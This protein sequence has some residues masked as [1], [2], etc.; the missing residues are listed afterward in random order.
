VIGAFEGQDAGLS[1]G[2]QRRLDRRFDRVGARGRE[3]G[4]HGHRRESGRIR[5][6]SLGAR[7]GGLSGA[8]WV[9]CEQLL[10]QLDLHAR[11]VDVSHSVHQRLGLGRDRSRD[12]GM[13]MADV[14]DPECCGEVDEAIAVDV[15]E[16]RAEG[17]LPEDR[18]G[19]EGGHVSALHPRES[20]GQR[21]GGRTRHGRAKRGRLGRD[22]VGGRRH[23]GSVDRRFGVGRRDRLCCGFLLGVGIQKGGPQ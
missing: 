12:T 11:R 6:S 7:L 1:R 18:D 17:P 21:P 4:P 13:R 14:G 23:G 8:R 9:E 5:G 15:P 3:Y 16:I 10:E 19:L 2:E 22:C 20:R